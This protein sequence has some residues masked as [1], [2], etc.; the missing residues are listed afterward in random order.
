MN[1]EYSI[2]SAGEDNQYG[3]PHGSVLKLVQKYTREKVFITYED[4]SILF[5]SDGKT[6]VNVIPNAGQDDEK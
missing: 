6:I 1:P 2:I 4:G 3:H 5:E